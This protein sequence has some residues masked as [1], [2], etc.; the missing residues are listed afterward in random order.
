MHPPRQGRPILA[1]DV[2]PGYGER[3]GSGPA[4]LPSADRPIE[5]RSGGQSSLAGPRSVSNLFA[6]KT[7]ASQPHGNT[8][9]PILD[10]NHKLQYKY[11]DI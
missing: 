1:Q 6:R 5:L 3:I 2:S 4:G 10:I 11:C 7:T 9:N 8:P